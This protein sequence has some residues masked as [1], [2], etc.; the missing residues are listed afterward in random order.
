MSEIGKA[1]ADLPVDFWF[2]VCSEISLLMFGPET[3]LLHPLQEVDLCK[4]VDK[5]TRLVDHLQLLDLR[6]LPKSKSILL[7]HAFCDESGKS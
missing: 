4:Y 6:K 2:G 3:C 5:A 1:G 7:A